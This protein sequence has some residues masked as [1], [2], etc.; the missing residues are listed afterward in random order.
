MD[1]RT[2]QA[3]TLWTQAQPTVSAYVHA[4]VGDR[5]ARDEVLQ[6]VAL[7]ILEHFGSYD[8]ERPFLPW[9]MTIARNAVAVDFDDAS[10]AQATEWP[11][12]RIAPKQPYLEHDFKC[13]KWIWTGDLDLD[14][15]VLFRKK[16]EKPSLNPEAKRRWTTKPD[17]DSAGETPVK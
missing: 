12:E 16:V 13:A 5:A 6:Q 11:E 7:A 15:T 1:E 9:A 4:L 17:I 2:R 14:N 10:W 3:F 8:S